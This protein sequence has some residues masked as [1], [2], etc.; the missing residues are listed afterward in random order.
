MRHIF[1]G[2]R[3]QTYQVDFMLLTQSD[4]QAALGI[5]MPVEEA[6]VRAQW[7][8]EDM[9]GSDSS[10]EATGQQSRKPSEKPLPKDIC[11]ATRNGMGCSRTTK[12]AHES[13]RR[14]NLPR[15]AALHPSAF[16]LSPPVTPPHR[17]TPGPFPARR[18]G[19]QIPGSN[20]FTS[21]K[22]PQL[23]LAKP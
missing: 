5:Y 1:A 2:G 3:L 9:R 12:E 18:G 8:F 14:R 13:F 16:I 22:L 6:A 17:S 4:I 20:R 23:S 21:Q 7:D 10:Y 11:L 15:R 19:K